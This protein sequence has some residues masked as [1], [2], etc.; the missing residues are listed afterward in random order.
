M[1]NRMTIGY[2]YIREHESYNKYNACKIGI[3]TNIPDRENVY[4][5]NEIKKGEFTRVYEV[6]KQQMRIIENLIHHR[7]QSF[8]IRINSG[9]EFFRKNIVVYLEPY[10][11]EL[12]IEYRLLNK[13]E[14]EN[15]LRRKRVKNNFRKV[16]S[17]LIQ[18]SK[19][20]YY[21]PRRYQ[22]KIIKNAI[23]YYTTHDKGLLVLPCGV[24]KTLI[25]LWIAKGLHSQRILI[26]VPSI[27][28][29]EQWNLVIPSLFQDVPVYKVYSTINLDDIIQFLKENASVYCLN[30]ISFLL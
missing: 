2:I 12:G 27:E 19:G 15:L 26:G 11:K 10:F 8:H 18:Y 17:S 7:F 5:T 23:K 9:T 1:N 22:N 3:T 21:T 16:S 20:N 13:K 25:S 29:I 6:K 28:L 24:G 14:I 4:M 30:D